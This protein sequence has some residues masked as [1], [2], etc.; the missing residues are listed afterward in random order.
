MKLRTVYLSAEIIDE[1][2]KRF[3]PHLRIDYARLCIWKI[4]ATHQKT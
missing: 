3:F 2:A 1:W 4:L